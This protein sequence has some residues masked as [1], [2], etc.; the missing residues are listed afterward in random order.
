MPFFFFFFP[1]AHNCV[2]L[3]QSYF[4]W[5]RQNVDEKPHFRPFLQPDIFNKLYSLLHAGY[6]ALSNKG[7]TLEFFHVPA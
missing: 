5:Q 6:G 7:E 1:L 4:S 2:N 3:E